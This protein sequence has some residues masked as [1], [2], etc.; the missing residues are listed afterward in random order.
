[1]VLKSLHS[2]IL[3]FFTAIFL[4]S[5]SFYLVSEATRTVRAES[6]SEVFENLEVK[7]VQL[8][9]G[10]YGLALVDKADMRI[11]VYQFNPK[12]PHGKLELIAARDFRYDQQLK[13]YNNAEPT[14]KKV[15]EII[16]KLGS[17]DD[18]IKKKTEKEL[19]WEIKP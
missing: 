19:M 1:M 18:I 7:T 10:I 2:W 16:E 4:L 13:D 6:E 15:R 11:L 3:L 8:G 9:N 17:V 12:S 5:G 14:P